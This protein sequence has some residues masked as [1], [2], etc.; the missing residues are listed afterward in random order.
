MGGGLMAGLTGGTGSL[1]LTP[2]HLFL[3]LPARQQVRVLPLHTVTGIRASTSRAGRFIL[4]DSIDLLGCQV[5]TIPLSPSQKTKKP[6]AD[7][8]LK[9][10]TGES[11]SWA[12][13][14]AQEPHADQD[15]TRSGRH[16]GG[17]G[18]VRS[19][20]TVSKGESKGGKTETGVG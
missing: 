10:T 13:P 4:K 1:Y 6:E 3:H 14:S 16:H 20:R 11:G 18:E 5:H 2:Q 12:D 7:G 19:G 17:S 9:G 15:E 8:D